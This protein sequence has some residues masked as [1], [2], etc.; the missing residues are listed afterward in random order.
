MRVGDHRLCYTIDDGKLLILIITIS[1]R[2][3][4]Y[5]LVRRYFGR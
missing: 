4:V 3:D 2:A 1:T 5:Q